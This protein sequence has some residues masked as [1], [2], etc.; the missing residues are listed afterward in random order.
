MRYLASPGSIKEPAAR[1]YTHQRL[2]RF[3]IVLP[4]T[5]A[6]MGTIAGSFPLMII[7]FKINFS[8]FFQILLLRGPF[9]PAS[10]FLFLSLFFSFL[11]FPFLYQ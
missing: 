8:L 9:L 11:L 1:V 7:Y 5:V 2:Y 3:P 4:I 10:F 6:R